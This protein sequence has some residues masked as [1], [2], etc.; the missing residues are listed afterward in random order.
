MRAIAWVCAGIVL[1]FALG[2]VPGRREAAGE[3]RRATR[4]ERELA[5]RRHGLPG[6]ASPL[7]GF[8]RMLTPEGGPPPP[9][10]RDLAR[11]ARAARAARADG[12]VEGPAAAAPGAPPPAPPAE[13]AGPEERFGEFD[14]LVEAQRARAAQSRA[15]LAE[16]AGLDE[17]DLR[18]VDR[19]LTRMND[20]LLPYGDELIAMAS[21]EAPPRPRDM[22]TLTHDV[23]GILAE[24]QLAFEQSVGD[25]AEQIEDESVLEVWNYVDLERFRPFVEQARAAEGHSGG[26]E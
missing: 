19:I 5:R 13:G 22:L 1:G 26:D 10:P 6:L 3:K 2:T 23:T 4:L 21:G 18:A 16:Q 7:P 25:G 20:E 9:R 14:T 11:S 17:D 24:A 15:A 8:D 12:G